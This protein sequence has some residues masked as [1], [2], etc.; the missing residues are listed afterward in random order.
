[1]D[2]RKVMKRGEDRAGQK[3]TEASGIGS[4]AGSVCPHIGPRWEGAHRLCRTSNIKPRAKG[5]GKR[6]AALLHLHIKTLDF[7]A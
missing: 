7:C 3:R 5:A 4:P 6:L 1:M 2:A